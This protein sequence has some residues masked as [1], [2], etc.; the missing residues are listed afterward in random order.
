VARYLA[1]L[2]LASAALRAI[3]RRSSA[4][5]ALALAFPPLLAPSRAKATAWMFFIFA[6]V[7][8]RI[9]DPHTG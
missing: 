9:Y 5:R 4:V 3:S 7:T 6:M 2:H 1:D 8:P